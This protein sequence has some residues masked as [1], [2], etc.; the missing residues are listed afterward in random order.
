MTYFP[1]SDYWGFYVGFLGLVFFFLAM[2]LGIFHRKAHVISF[3]EAATW[4]VI[5]MAAAVL[6][7]FGFYQYCL[8]KFTV[9]TQ[10]HSIQGF[11]GVLTSKRLALEFLT[12][13]VVEQFLSIDNIFV[14][15]IIFN[16][17]HVP[18]K[19]QHRILFF[20]ILGALLFRGIF[21]ALGAS[22]LQYTWVMIIFGIFLMVTGFKVMFAPEKTDLHP[23][24]NFIIKLI[25]KFFP[26]KTNAPEGKFWVRESGKFFITPLFITLVFVEL[27]DVVFA[28]DSVP[29]I[30]AIT[31]EP[32]I[33]LT[34]NIF[35]IMGL[36]SLFFMLSG[37]VGKFHLL[38]YGLG[39][40]LVFIGN[41]MSWL[42]DY[43]GGHFPIGVSLAI[44]LGL[45]ALSVVMS[46]VIKPKNESIP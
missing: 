8:H 12:G 28:I 16:F 40:V 43:Y 10:F 27:T 20:G 1:F 41:K 21:I 36:R 9:D 24:Q 37:V 42:N 46:L 2:D 17:F 44:I 29:A 30:F 26:V 4:T 32:F 19:F 5:W 38:K 6:F 35:A 11:D 13:Y 34:S 39:L 7:C 45:I 3:K 15:I 31:K 33:V 18:K 23:D 25:K 22:L 14:F